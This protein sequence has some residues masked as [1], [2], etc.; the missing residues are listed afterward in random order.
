MKYFRILYVFFGVALLAGCAS[1]PNP[2]NKPTLAG[3]ENAY[4]AALSVAVGYRDACSA[5]LIPPSCR[6]IVKE[7]QTYG[8]KAQA[9]IVV[10]RSF[11]KN[12]PTLDI[13]STLAAAQAAVDDFKNAET[14]LG[15]K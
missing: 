6:P 14:R 3:V 13:T 4:G 11:V 15:V 12:N 9:S 8:A 5:R 1:I 10:A 2:F 7:V